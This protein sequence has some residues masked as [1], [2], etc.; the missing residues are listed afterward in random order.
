MFLQIDIATKY[1]PQLTPDSVYSL[2]F[3]NPGTSELREKLPICLATPTGS[4]KLPM[5]LAT[6]TGIQ[7]EG[8]EFTA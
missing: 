7:N 8:F 5:S 1:P 6:P 2:I 4:E 3:I